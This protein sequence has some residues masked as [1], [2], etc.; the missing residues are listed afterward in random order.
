[1][2]S[3]LENYY[4]KLFILTLF[5][6]AFGY[7]EASVVIYLRELYYPFGFHVPIEVGFPWIKFGIIPQLKP[8]PLEILFVEIGREISTII[9]LATLAWI[10]AENWK[11]RLAYFLWPFAIWDI[12]YYIF[13]RMIIN[14]PESLGTIDILFLIPLP[15]IAP[16]WMPVLGSMVFLITSIF[17]LKTKK[18]TEKSEQ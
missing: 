2:I 12:F 4:K 7:L 18:E 11:Q 13:L 10:S 6:I 9:M 1:M 3:F 14:W 16:V 17:L 8:V 15:W 5:G